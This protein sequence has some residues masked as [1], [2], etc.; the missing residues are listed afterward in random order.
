VAIV[1]HVGD[2]KRLKRLHVRENL[3]LESYG[4]IQVKDRPL[5]PAAEIVFETIKRVHDR[6]PG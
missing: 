2:S 4:L 1:E 6:R 5:S 3:V